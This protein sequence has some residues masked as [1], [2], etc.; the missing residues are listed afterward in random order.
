MNL[1][2]G[3]STSERNTVALCTSPEG[4]TRLE[5]EQSFPKGDTTYLLIVGSIKQVHMKS[6]SGRSLDQ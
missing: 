6:V 1:V 5:H 2:Q 3:Y 4:M